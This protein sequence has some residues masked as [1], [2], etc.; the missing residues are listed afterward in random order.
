MTDE[1]GIEA[2]SESAG[3]HAIEVKEATPA[4]AAAKKPA[5]K[6]AAAKKKPAAKKKATK[7]SA[8]TAKAD[9][10][11]RSAKGKN[12][13]IVESPAKART[14]SAI[15][16]RGYDV[17]ASVGHVR[18]LPKSQLGVD[19]DD[20]FAPRYIVPKDKKEIVKQLKAAA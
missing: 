16:G 14:L 13:V 7:A 6:K 2:G 18:D 11:Q 20:N 3:E 4:K 12:L 15:L 1:M 17:R 19:V 9:K 10:A 5:A 8:S